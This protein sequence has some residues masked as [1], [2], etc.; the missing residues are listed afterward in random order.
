MKMITRR[1]ILSLLLLFT[2]IAGFGQDSLKQISKAPV[3]FENDTLFYINYA[4]NNI[5]LT[6]RAELIS[7][8][9]EK[10]YGINNFKANDLN[11]QQDSAFSSIR[12]KDLTIMTITDE[13]AQI[14]DLDRES[15]AK[16]YFNAIK[17]KLDQY[18]QFKDIRNVLLFIAEA[19]AVILGLVL[20]IWL[21]NRFFRKFLYRFLLKQKYPA[22]SLGNYTILSP[23]KVGALVRQALKLLRL[24]I[25]L[26]AIYF[27]LPIL[28]NIFPWTQPLAEKLINYVVAPIKKILHA[29]VN[30]I[31]NLLTIF[32][33]YLF[34][35]Y[36]VRAVKFLA[37]E[38][39]RGI[40]KINGFYADWAQPTFKI[41]KVLLYTLMFVAIF[42]YLPGSQSKVFQGVSVFL[43]ILISLGSSSAISNMIAGVVITYM[44][45]FRI[46][47]RIKVG[48]VMGDVIEKTLLVTRLRTIKNEEITIPNAIILSG[49]TINY[50]VACHESKGLILHT[51]VTIGYDVPWRQVHDLLIN[52]A[53]KTQGIIPDPKPFVLQTSL[54]DYYP[55]YQL[56]AYT[57]DASKMALTYSLLHQSIQ[58]SF[59]EAGVE[60]MSPHYTA[61][62]DGN[63][64]AMPEDSRPKGEPS[65]FKIHITKKTE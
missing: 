20:L 61:L 50:T 7:N 16:N 10:V 27:A 29:I 18:A 23:G 34:T 48:E 60:I 33:I 59:N 21:I 44:R 26:I 35:R 56:N 5:S 8:R 54:E 49:Q 32:V 37:T 57:D 31:P 12:Y 63:T 55:S 41:V 11:L 1:Y 4:P 3:L 53:L 47:D 15:L 65:T 13:D 38:V 43:G 42:P 28:F 36:V 39:E 6:E 19:M 64:A 30:Y 52:A 40:L 24:V 51:T 58:D 9:I 46:G 45:P 22:F 17:G 2:G 25:I 14:N 62:R